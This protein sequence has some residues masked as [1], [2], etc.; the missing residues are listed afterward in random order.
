[1]VREPVD[2]EIYMPAAIERV[3]NSCWVWREDGP[4]VKEWSAKS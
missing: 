1:M 3:R 2:P 4:L